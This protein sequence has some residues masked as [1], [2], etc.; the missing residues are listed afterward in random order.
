MSKRFVVI[1]LGC[2]KNLVDGEGMQQKLIEVGYTQTDKLRQADAV[3]VNTCGFID[4]AKEESIQALLEVAAMKRPGQML[5]AAGCLS[6]RYAADLARDIP[7]IDGIL[8]TRRWGE[9]AALLDQAESGENPCWTGKSSGTSSSS[10]AATSASAYVKIADGCSVGCAFCAIPKI[11][12]PHISKPIEDI[13]AEARQLALQ[14]VKELV[15]VAQNSTA[16]G[17]DWG[18]KDALAMLLD[19]LAEHVPEI[20]WV[21][22]MYA[23]PDHITPKLI[24]TM[25]RNEKVLKYIDLPLQHADPSIL[26]AMRRPEAYPGHIIRQLRESIPDVAIRSAFIVGFPGEGEKEFSNLL[27]FLEESELDRVGVFT[28]SSEEGTLAATLPDHVSKRVARKRFER[29]MELQ[30][31]ISLRKNREF[32][33]KT[34]DVLIEGIAESSSN[35]GKKKRQR[36]TNHDDISARSSNDGRN[37]KQS[38]VFLGRSYRDAPEVD[39]TVFVHGSAKIGEIVP[40]RITDALEYDLVGE[41]VSSIKET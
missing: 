10:R 40:V 11:K 20:A 8:G 27:A 23:F 34:L 5:I 25:A 31:G 16:Y 37:A 24:E 17:H 2:P 21:R 38:V 29:A 26:R 30:Q 6:E 18:E 14:G 15:L 7:E 35:G 4:K 3:I 28:Y 32:V 19:R 12:G 41:V 39:G 13:V 36:S 9:I 1:N 22:L 33:G